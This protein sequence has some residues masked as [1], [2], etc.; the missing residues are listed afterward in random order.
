MIE[1]EMAKQNRAAAKQS[2]GRGRGNEAGNE[3]CY[4]F[5]LIVS[6]FIKHLT[7]CID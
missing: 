2:R 4:R 6:M 5:K 7:M 3:N 1:K